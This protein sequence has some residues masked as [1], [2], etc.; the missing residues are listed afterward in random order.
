M[1]ELRDVTKTYRMGG[2]VI[3]AL[4]GINLRIEKGEFLSIVGPSGSGKSTLLNIIGCI[5]SPS[6][7]E[8]RLDGQLVS[9]LNDRALTKI[10]LNKIGF[11]FQQF[12]LI[13]TLKAQE[14]VELPMKEARLPRE[15]RENRAAHLLAQVGLAERAKHI[16]ASSRGGSSRGWP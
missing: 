12:Y 14:N 15:E 8:V 6:S 4:N 2:T 13:P 9:M 7:G 11:I 3:W 5:D 16:Q 1:I 10:R